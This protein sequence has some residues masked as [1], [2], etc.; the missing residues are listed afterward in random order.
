M[1]GQVL[2]SSVLTR[3]EAECQLAYDDSTVLEHDSL[4][5]VDHR[6][7]QDAEEAENAQD[8]DTEGSHYT[9]DPDSNY[10]TT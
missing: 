7:L 10:T 6:Q 5:G 8:S 4:L 3:Q 1:L 2:Y 9:G